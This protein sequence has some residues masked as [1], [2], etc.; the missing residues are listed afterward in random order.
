[1]VWVFEG[2]FFISFSYVYH[3]RT[4]MP[5]ENHISINYLMTTKE[6]YLMTSWS[7]DYQGP[8]SHGPHY[9]MITNGEVVDIYVT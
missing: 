6:H 5:R 3:T 4:F 2:V 7:H 9:L 1:M 8:F